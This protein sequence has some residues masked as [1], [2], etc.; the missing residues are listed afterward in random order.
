MKMAIRDLGRV[1][2]ADP[3][4][5]DRMAKNV[6]P[7]DD[8]NPIAAIKHSTILQAYAVSH[9]H[10]LKACVKVIGLPRQVSIHP[11]GVVLSSKVLA[12]VVPVQLGQ[13]AEALTQYT[14]EH[15]EELGLIKIDILSLRSLTIIQLVLALIRERTGREI[16]LS[17]LQ[18]A[19]QKTFKML[20]AGLTMGIFQLES[21]GMRRVLRQLQV[22]SIED[23][24]ATSALFRPGPQEQ[25]GTY[26]NRKHEQVMQIA[27]AVAGFSYARADILRRA[28][29]K[30]EQSM[31]DQLGD[32]FMQGALKQ[33]YSNT[34]ATQVFDYIK[35]FGDYG[36]N[37]AHA[38]GYG[39]IGLGDPGKLTQYS[40]DAKSYKIE[41][42]LP[43]LNSSSG[44]FEIEKE[45]LRLPLSLI[46]GLGTV[47]YN[48]LANERN[49]YGHF[50]S[51]V[52]AYA[53]LRKSG[54]SKKVIETLVMAGAFD[55]FG[56]TRKT[57]ITNFELL[58]NHF[59]IT[60][61]DIAS[62]S[63]KPPELIRCEE[64]PVKEKM[65]NQVNAIGFDL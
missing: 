12:S 40:Q 2:S 17:R 33:G 53:R 58:E 36:F 64:Y 21:V 65:E 44:Q 11:A 34:D 43:D 35:R 26:A 47:A 60:N 56:E 48:K 55:Q 52:N 45:N 62:N 31:L 15:L 3:I 10:I 39:I 29:S 51:I 13:S 32:E 23:I 9:E 54:V 14:S 41:L 7:E 30:K 49:L 1:F 46:K 38:V 63:F 42:L 8:E 24:I 28:I 19:D 4:D 27:Q 57:I 5:I 37:R 59:K 18:L 61:G 22:D 20:S 6:P 25:I 16:D 50:T